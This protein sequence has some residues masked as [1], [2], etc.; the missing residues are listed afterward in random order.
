MPPSGPSGS[1]CSQDVHTSGCHVLLV[2]LLH[3]RRPLQLCAAGVPWLPSRSMGAVLVQHS[4]RTKWDWFM[5]GLGFVWSWSRGWCCI[6]PSQLPW[7][8]SA[9]SLLQESEETPMQEFALSRKD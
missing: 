2:L 1:I 7:R 5:A 8:A 9:T 4:W 3:G 6:A